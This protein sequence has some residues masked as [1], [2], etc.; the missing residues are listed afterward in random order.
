[1][2]QRFTWVVVAYALLGVSVPAGAQEVVQLTSPPNGAVLTAPVGSITL[3]WQ[4]YNGAAVYAY[5]LRDSMG[6]T[7]GDK[8]QNP[9]DKN[10]G[11]NP[12]EVGD[13]TQ[14][15]LYWSATEEV[16]DW[17]VM[18]YSDDGY[19]NEIARSATWTF[20]VSLVTPIPT[21]TLPG[22]TPTPVLAAP[23][24]SAPPDG[25][26]KTIAEYN[27]TPGLFIWQPVT[28]AFDYEVELVGPPDHGRRSIFTSDTT[29]TWTEKPPTGYPVSPPYPVSGPLTWRVRGRTAAGV[30]GGWSA[31]WALNL[32]YEL[33]ED[34]GDINGDDQ[35]DFKDSFEFVRS[36]QTVQ[37]EENFNE[38]ADLWAD[39]EI[40]HKDLL[41]FRLSYLSER[42]R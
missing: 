8:N 21:P 5:W 12:H 42:Q 14:V 28:G 31:Q 4:P 39:G 15:T 38:N 41:E 3:T 16:W 6:N 17:Y 25:S 9:H 19:T 18:A 33:V 22:P 13:H 32:D 35:V 34:P 23:V 26:Q 1:M 10:P 24:L 7:I 20:E 11:E 27:T 29:I 36:W 2:F 40:E 30:P 37:G